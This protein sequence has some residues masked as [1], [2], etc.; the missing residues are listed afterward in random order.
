MSKIRGK[1]IWLAS[2]GIFLLAGLSVFAAFLGSE[3]A[4]GVFNSVPLTISWLIL[5]TLLVVS[6]IAL[7]NIR[8]RP[9]MMAIHLGTLLII[10]G[11]MWGSDYAHELRHR[12]LGRDKL[13]FGQVK[14]QP[15][16]VARLDDLQL[17]LEKAWV[18]YYP[19]AQPHWNFFYEATDLDTTEVTY[20]PV[21]WQ[22]DQ[23]AELGKSGIR[24]TVLEYITDQSSAGRHGR[25]AP[26]VIMLELTTPS[27]AGSLALRVKEES[28]RE[29]LPLTMLFETE[30]AWRKA[31]FPK[32]VLELPQAVADYKAELVVSDGSGQL[33]RKVIEVNDPLHCGGY[34][35]YL[36]D[37]DPTGR[38]VTI[39]AHSD[40]GLLVVYAGF[41]LLML[42]LIVNMW[43]RP[44]WRTL[45]RRTTA[46][47]THQQKEMG[48]HDN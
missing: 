8:R 20:Q 38:V 31:G 5:A 11:A 36:S 37:S 42:G 34:H 13:V 14:L 35:F 7:R 43:L 9:G 30:D 18:E 28:V 39:T 10:C 48:Q 32:I 3:K 33:A 27:R 26:P 2:A 41:G 17:K 22:K 25:L 24:M 23:P 46:G 21:Y 40:S 6:I 4:R 1:I 12:W 45:R 44:A 29:T 16:M 47:G 19:P 15:G